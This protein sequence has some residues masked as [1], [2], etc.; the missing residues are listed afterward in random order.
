MSSDSG[1]GTG[2]PRVVID[3]TVVTGETLYS[4]AGRY[5][6]SVE[7]LMKENSVADARKLRAGTLL[8]VSLSSRTAR[9]L[10]IERFVE[11]SESHLRGARF[12]A[13]LESA[14]AARARLEKLPSS[15]ERKSRARLEIVSATVHMALGDRGAALSCLGR[16]LQADS[17][18]AL[19]PAV[20][21]PKVLRVLR[22]ARSPIP[23]IPRAR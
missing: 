7:R 4:L 13:A 21:S 1:T 3:H 9:R 15:S 2:P 10:E 6:S 18:L 19:D 17:D 11:R 20:V 22:A 14:D 5:G 16:A 12:E 23:D 8:R